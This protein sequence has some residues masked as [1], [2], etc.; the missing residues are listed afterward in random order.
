MITD[1]EGPN[2][3]PR[4]AVLPYVN[5][6]P[7]ANYLCDVCP[8]AE[9]IYMPPRAT[10]S[11]LNSGQADAA[12][13]PAADLPAACGAAPIGDCGIASDGPVRSV[14]LESAVDLAAV[15]TVA[16]DPESHTANAMAR[17][18]LSDQPIRF[19]APGEP[20][21]ARVVIGDRALRLAPGP[22]TYDLAELW[23]RRTGKPFVFAVWLCRQDHPQRDELDAAVREACRRGLESLELLAKMAAGRI[24]LAADD[25]LHYLSRNLTYR[26]GPAHQAG[27]ETF[28]A[29]IAEGKMP[30]IHAGKMPALQ[31]TAAGCSEGVPPSC[32]AGVS[33]A[34]DQDNGTTEGKMP[35]LHAGK[36]P[37]LQE[38]AAGCSEGACGERSRTVPPSCIA[39]VSP[40]KDRDNSRTEGK[41]PSL[42]AGKMPALQSGRT[43][44]KMPSIHAGKMP[45]LQSGKTEGKVPALHETSPGATDRMRL[46]LD[47]ALHLLEH[48]PLAELMAAANAVR[49]RLHGRRSYFVHS[50]NLNPSNVCHNECGLCAFWRSPG[51]PDAYVLSLDRA[52]QAMR[53][54]ADMK[55][56]ELHV[57]GGLAPGLDLAYYTALFCQARR[58]LGGIC[59]QGLTAVEIDHLAR[60]AGLSL[61]ATLARLRESGL[62][63]LPGGGAEIFADEV[64]ARICPRKIS[65]ARWLEVHRTAHAMGMRT[66]ATMLVGHVETPSH[67]I[68]HLMRLRELQ[69][70]TGGFGAFC[71][72]PFRPG[73]TRIGVDRGADANM[74]VRV[75]AVARA[76]LDNFPHVRVLHNY[77]SRKL[78]QTLL[79]AG[80]DDVG[81][82]SLDERI[83]LAAGSRPVSELHDP[84]AMAEMIR[85]AGM[86]PV[87]TDSLYRTGHRDVG[88]SGHRDSGTTASTQTPRGSFATQVHGLF[89][90]SRVAMSRVPRILELYL[91]APLHELSEMATERRRQVVP[92]DAVTF[93]IDRNINF[94]NACASGCAFCAFHVPPG[95]RRRFVLSVPQVVEMARQA[96]A[97]GATQVLLQGGLDPD[98][99]PDYYLEMLREVKRATG[100]WLHSLCPAEV[101]WLALRWGVDDAAA[102]VRLRQAGLD[103]L[104]GGGA[105]ML[106]DEVRARVSPRKISA[107]D[108]LAVMR[109]AHR[110]GMKSTATMVYGLGETPRQRVEHLMRIRQLQDETGGFTAFIPWSYQPTPSHPMPRQSGPEYLRVVALSRLILDNVPHV[111]AGWVTEGTDLAQMALSFGADD[112]GGVLMEEQVV[113]SAGCAVAKASP[114]DIAHLIRRAGWRPVQRATDY[115]PIKDW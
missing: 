113:S 57:V 70:A 16:A 94:C 43:E 27:L 22:H 15:R 12:I 5:T 106:I 13:V 55:L 111:Q 107:N 8:G 104:P 90:E 14:L 26:L 31:E 58:I 115:T 74:I 85:Q 93:V 89:P 54:A 80:V 44:G 108:W 76:V 29:G 32:I 100:L 88:T 83:A 65:G 109:A 68:D 60:E 84:A 102:L 56:T 92:G 4:F 105:E 25:C 82:T 24:G 67:I 1:R 81:G 110:I 6:L 46:S 48:A 53:A 101:R 98:I 7:L 41:M 10:L 2:T 114:E 52:T 72:L 38:T 61:H 30:S 112:F 20:A 28:L 66:N 18:L 47:E 103:S 45:A 64:R 40:A 17:V 78:L 91:H 42:H 86:T 95:D 36:M 50:L 63:C 51:A 77:V 37:A 71:L 59:I 99:E 97:A 69:D 35:S 96:A 33:P 9:L 39:G 73:Q 21:D 3:M 34:K 75:T 23:T 87:L 79:H 49:Q 62:D 11:A 19:V